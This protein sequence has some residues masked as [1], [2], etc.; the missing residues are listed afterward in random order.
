MMAVNTDR[1]NYL[2]TVILWPGAGDAVGISQGSSVKA[3][4]VVFSVGQPHRL[5][6]IV[7]ASNASVA[8]EQAFTD[9]G[10]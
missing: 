3:N 7:A 1:A 5:G 10:A 9:V 6:V 2:Q 4:A 8:E